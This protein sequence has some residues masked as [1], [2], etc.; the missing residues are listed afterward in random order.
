[1]AL[2][3]NARNLLRREA[4][5]PL[6]FERGLD[7]W[8]RP[9]AH[10]IGFE[11]LLADAPARAEIA[12]ESRSVVA[13][14]YQCGCAGEAL[15]REQRRGDTYV[16][17]PARAVLDHGRR[18]AGAQDLPARP[19]VFGDAERVARAHVLQ[20]KEPR[21]DRS[22]AKGVP[23]TRAVVVEYRRVQRNPGTG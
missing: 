17:A 11:I 22:A 7:G 21:G 13:F 3:R 5:R 6:Q 12:P 20:R 16:R 8:L 14:G 19:E 9:A 18:I 15:A 4:V 1:K 2:D 23:R 10:R